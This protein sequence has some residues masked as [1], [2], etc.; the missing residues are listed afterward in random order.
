MLIK[1]SLNKISGKIK[2]PKP[3]FRRIS[4]LLVDYFKQNMES[5]GMKLLKG[6]WKELS[7]ATIAAKIRLG[8]GS[9]KILERTGKLKK[10]MKQLSLN[11]AELVVGNDVKYYQYHQLGGRKLPKRQMLGVN[12]DVENIV[13]DQFTKAISF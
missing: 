9:K 10:G 12:K 3:I 11:N 4:P 8:Y 2:D 6:R 5:E 7:P 1:Q 13:M